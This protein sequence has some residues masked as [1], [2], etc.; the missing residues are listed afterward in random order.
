MSNEQKIAELETQ[1][2]KLQSAFSD[3]SGQFYKNN[4]SS[5]QVF[6]KDCVFQGRL[7]VPVLSGV[8]NVAEIG[9]IMAISGVLYICTATSPITFTVVGSQS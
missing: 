8:P 1:L 6:T 5:N 3:L 2:I 4:F 9:D 7:K